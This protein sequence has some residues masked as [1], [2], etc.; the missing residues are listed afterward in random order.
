[1]AGSQSIKAARA[2]LLT[3]CSTLYGS[4]TDSLNAP[5]QVVLGFPSSYQAQNIVSVGISTRQPVTRPTLT[6]NRSR[7]KA[8]TVTV[9]FSMFRAGTP[10]AAQQGVADDCDDL[11][12]LLE[13]YFQ[14]AGNERLGGA[15]RD[16]YVSSIDG[17]TL[18]PSY[19]EKRVVGYTATAVATVT[20]FIRY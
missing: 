9:T 13:G 19:R 2:A 8:C 16:A 3:A 11:V 12:A 18:A 14:V 10:D 17:P 6:T 20:I 15:S 1:M 4:V 7:D 5:V